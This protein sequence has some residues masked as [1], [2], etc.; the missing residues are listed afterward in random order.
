MT[1]GVKSIL[2]ATLFFSA[3][4]VL[5]KMLSHIPAV[6]LALFRSVFTL[7]TSYII[8][9]KLGLSIFGQKN[10]L[11]FLRGIFGTISLI[12][13]F[14]SVHN[15][16]LA[17]A[18]LVH[19]LTPFF[20]TFFGYLFLK[21]KFY[22]IQ[23]LF[24]LICF[25]GILITQHE[26]GIFNTFN[27]HNAGLLFGLGASVAAAGAYNCIRKISA[28]YN[29]NV[30]MIYFPIV[31]IPI[32][33]VTLI[34]NGGFVMPVAKDWIL[35]FFMAMLTQAAQYYLTVAYQN[36]KVGNI[37]VF[38]NLGIVYAVFSGIIF[39]AEIPS[40]ISLI[41]IIIVASG[42]FLNLFSDKIFSIIR[43]FK[44]VIAK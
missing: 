8:I 41:G 18:T 31:A 16:P 12:F 28:T 15:L 42:I 3:M 23:W 43:N 20:T 24:L 5:V 38:S 36:E 4:N 32:C 25:A 21:E 35:I 11:L 1:K 7:I 9:R 33:T 13:F 14:K 37:A 6:E 34:I 17:T 40:F 22:R 29:P 30:I 27:I 2:I 39:F 10:P 26:K 19:Y 44:N